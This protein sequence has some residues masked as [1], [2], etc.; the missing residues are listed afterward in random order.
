MLEEK[1]YFNSDLVDVFEDS[2]WLYVVG[3]GVKFI[4]VVNN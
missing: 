2:R 3:I 1:I 4:K